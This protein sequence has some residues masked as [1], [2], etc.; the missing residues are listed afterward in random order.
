MIAWAWA[1]VVSWQRTRWPTVAF[2]L[3]LSPAVAF[4]TTVAAPN[5]MGYAAGLLMWAGLLSACRGRRSAHVPAASAVGASV[6]V[7]THPTGMIWVGGAVLTV[8][9]LVGWRGVREILLGRPLAWAAGIGGVAVVIAFTVAWTL[10][11]AP[12]APTANEPLVAE[13]KAIPMVGHVI[14]WIFQTVGV[15][16]NRF[17]LLWPIVYALWLAPLGFLLARAIRRANRKDRLAGSVAMAVAVLIPTVATVM[18][19][20][21]VG[22]AWQ[23]R[24]ELPLLVG[25]VMLA[26]EVLDR[27][28]GVASPLVWALVAL[29]AVTSYLCLL[30]LGLREARG[31]YDDGRPWQLL[32]LGIAPALLAVGYALLGRSSRVGSV[33]A[34]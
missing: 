15:M 29:V 9:L 8:L 10:I 16:P 2:L 28:A 22:V 4:A 11:Y 13:T 17:G 5:G 24:Y 6:V 23:G 34:E 32:L 20:D 25:I 30:C 7:L 33:Q 3:A 14:L 12:N 31:P 27:G 19:Y 1:I 26:G 18:T 21:A